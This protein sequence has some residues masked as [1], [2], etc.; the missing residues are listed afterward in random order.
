M[1]L[2]CPTDNVNGVNITFEVLAGQV[3]AVQGCVAGSGCLGD[4]A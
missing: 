2:A 3:D 4:G 1:L